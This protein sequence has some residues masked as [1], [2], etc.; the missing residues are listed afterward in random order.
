MGPIIGAAVLAP[1]PFLLQQYAS[2]KDVIYGSLVIAVVV[3]MPSGL[4][5]ELLHYARRW[6]GAVRLKAFLLGEMRR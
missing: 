4:Y 3:L 1:V 6:P 2:L 5:G